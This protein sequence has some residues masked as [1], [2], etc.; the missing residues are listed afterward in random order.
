M[1][2]PAHGDLLVVVPGVAVVEVGDEALEAVP[3]PF[4]LI[5]GHGGPV[6]RPCP[7]GV[8]V[9]VGGCAGGRESSGV[10]GPGVRQLSTLVVKSRPELTR[11]AI[12][13]VIEGGVRRF[14]SDYKLSAPVE[15]DNPLVES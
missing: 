11:V 3:H 14:H 4:C 9:G 8:K 10:I 15:V 12:T 7:A 1:E 5:A 2:G 13:R 6:P